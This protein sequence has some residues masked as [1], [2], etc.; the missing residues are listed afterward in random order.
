MHLDKYHFRYLNQTAHY[1]FTSIGP[2]GKIKKIVLFSALVDWGSNTYNLGF[3]DWIEAELDV[4]DIVIS[5]NDDRD[6]VLATVAAITLHFINLHPDAI[7]VIK[8]STASRTRLYQMAI[9]KYFDELSIYFHFSGLCKNTWKE[10][11]K[12]E[13]YDAIVA[14]SKDNQ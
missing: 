14:I 9:N 11:E 2:K 1:E 8:G 4:S 3:G 5:D 10:F 13:N 12:M 7:L 6:K